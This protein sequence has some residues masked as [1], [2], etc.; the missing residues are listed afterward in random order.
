M[1]VADD[2]GAYN[3]DGITFFPALRLAKIDLPFLK[4]ELAAVRDEACVDWIRMLMSMGGESWS[5]R[6]SD[7]LWPDYEQHAGFVID[8]VSDEFGMRSWLDLM[9]EVMPGLETPSE[10]RAHVERCARIINARPHKIQGVNVWNEPPSELLDEIRELTTYLQSLVPVLVAP[11]TV[12][13]EESI[14]RLYSNLGNRLSVFETDRSIGGN[15]NIREPIWNIY[16]WQHVGNTCGGIQRRV[17]NIEPIGPFSSQYAEF[18]PARNVGRKAFAYWLGA[19]MDCYHNGVFMR[20]G[21]SWDVSRMDHGAWRVRDRFG[22]ETDTVYG[23]IPKSAKQ[24]P[25]WAE[26]MRGFR[27][28]KALLPPGVVNYTRWPGHFHGDNPLQVN[29]PD[30]V[31]G[32]FNFY[33]DT[34]AAFKTLCVS[35]GSRLFYGA[36]DVRRPVP[37]T[38]SHRAMTVR[39]H[40]L[41]FVGDVV[42]EFT[43][44]AGESFELS[45]ERPEAMFSAEYV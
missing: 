45:P 22:R 38:A 36:L 1:G 32:Q 41:P 23:P 42:R 5:D 43:V 27:E 12:G 40:A 7:P 8:L 2:G 18:D 25:F 20:L 28:L 34:G 19:C 13:D 9:S 11:A 26:T 33:F 6:F 39:E 21:G 35:D 16:E 17:V 24:T 15:G 31:P 4:S 3:A 30:D 44:K 29:H 14:C 37:V 10:R